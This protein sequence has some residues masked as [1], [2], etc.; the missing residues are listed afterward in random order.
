MLIFH[1]IF[2]YKL[3]GQ[4]KQKSNYHHQI[5]QRVSVQRQKKMS[6]LNLP[7]QVLS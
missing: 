3:E 4:E 1:Y 5:M 2:T 7:L 6:I